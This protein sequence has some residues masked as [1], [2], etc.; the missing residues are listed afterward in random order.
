MT[1]FWLS[2]NGYAGYQTGS[3]APK[4][5][6]GTLGITRQWRASKRYNIRGILKDTR[7][8]SLTNAATP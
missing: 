2:E 3:R 8:T 1:K 5:K 7:E 4:G 6:G